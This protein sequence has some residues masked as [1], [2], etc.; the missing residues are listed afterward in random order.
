MDVLKWNDVDEISVK[1]FPYKGKMYDVKGISVR[2][3]SRFGEDASGQE[4]G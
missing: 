3:L 2:W 1:K 4:Y